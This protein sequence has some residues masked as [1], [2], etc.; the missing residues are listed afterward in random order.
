MQGFI[1][2]F[3]FSY[4]N[5]NNDPP[6]YPQLALFAFTLFDALGFFEGAVGGGHVDG[7]AFEQFFD[8]QDLDAGVFL[9]PEGGGV[10]SGGE[11]LASNR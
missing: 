6:L 3:T 4:L 9:L 1:L 7:L 5:S 8:A 11:A 10:K 2:Y